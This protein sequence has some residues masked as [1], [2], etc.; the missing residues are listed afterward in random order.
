M[1][2]CMKNASLRIITFLTIVSLL[3]LTITSGCLET[4]EATPAKV[5]SEALSEYGW[6]RIGDVAYESQ[7][8]EISGTVIK[9]NTAMIMYQDEQLGQDMLA[10]LSKLQSQY[11]VQVDAQLPTVGSQLMTLRVVLP[12]GIGLPSSATS[13]LIDSQIDKM[14]RENN[15][16]NFKKVG[17]R[18][19][20]VNDGSVI[21]ANTYSG[22][23]ALDGDVNDATIDVM[24]IIAPWSSSGS[25]IFAIGVV[26]DGDIN[27]TME[28]I[29]KTIIT[30]NGD[31]EIDE[32]VEMIKTIN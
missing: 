32:I 27:L 18:E 16:E 20:T 4:S 7:E 12:G 13:S 23:T 1:V 11:N 17:T 10:E 15:I 31:D 25:N 3:A 26:P 6:V 28:P 19:I 22:T 30:I 29:E 21:T 14:A 24:A 5:S 8:E 2:I 9:V